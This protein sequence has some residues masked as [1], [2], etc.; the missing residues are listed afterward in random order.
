MFMYLHIR[1]DYQCSV[2]HCITGFSQIIL[3]MSL[4]I[5]GLNIPIMGRGIN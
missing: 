4:Q 2:L 3:M 5:Q 1:Y